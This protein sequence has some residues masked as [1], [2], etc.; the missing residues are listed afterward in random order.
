MMSAKS[1]E[2]ETFRNFRQLIDQAMP[3]DTPNE[4]SVRR[5]LGRRVAAPTESAIAYGGQET[6]CP[7][8]REHHIACGGRSTICTGSADGT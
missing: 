6:I 8:S 4:K 7:G 3:A 5:E 2:D 1:F